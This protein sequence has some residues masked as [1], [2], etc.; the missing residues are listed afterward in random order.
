MDQLIDAVN[1]KLG[2]NFLNEVEIC[3]KKEI[4]FY[5]LFV[6]GCHIA[7]IHIKE[8]MLMLKFHNCKENKIFEIDNPN[9]FNPNKFIRFLKKLI[10]ERADLHQYT[11]H[12]NHPISS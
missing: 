1:E 4:G 3:G 9:D 8:N 6:S 5:K 2:G 11:R 7:N 10:N 12:L